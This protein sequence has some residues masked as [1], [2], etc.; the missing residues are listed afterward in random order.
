LLD[1]NSKVWEPF[2]ADMEVACDEQL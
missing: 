1:T 2:I